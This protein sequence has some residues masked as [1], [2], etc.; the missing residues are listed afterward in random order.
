MLYFELD[1]H[2]TPKLSVLTGLISVSHS[3]DP[4]TL[5][6]MVGREMYNSV[7]YVDRTKSCLDPEVSSV[8]VLP[9]TSFHCSGI[10]VP[11]VSFPN[12][13]TTKRL[14]NSARENYAPSM[15]IRAA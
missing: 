12:R 1:E 4:Q 10:D 9:S 5:R 14:L 13:G 3:V 15:S 2:S 7:Q 6:L 11:G 8:R